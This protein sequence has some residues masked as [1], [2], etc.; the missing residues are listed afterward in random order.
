MVDIVSKGNKGGKPN[1]ELLHVTWLAQRILSK[2][3]L[4]VQTVDDVNV[5]ANNIKNGDKLVNSPVAKGKTEEIL[6]TDGK[7]PVVETL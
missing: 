6:A 4:N 7:N 5:V 2:Q 1:W 3:A